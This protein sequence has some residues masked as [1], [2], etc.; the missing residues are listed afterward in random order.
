[1]TSSSRVNPIN[2]D[3]FCHTLTCRT[4]CDV[5]KDNEDITNLR[6]HI[7]FVEFHSK[8]CNFH[9]AQGC[10]VCDK[11]FQFTRARNKCL[12]KEVACCL[13]SLGSAEQS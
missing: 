3:H 4:S 11:H 10:V 5:C 7:D 6:W 2:P 9:N 8:Y 1:M 12:Q 13:V